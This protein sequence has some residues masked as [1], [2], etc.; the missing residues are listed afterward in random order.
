[1]NIILGAVLILGALPVGGQAWVNGT[2]MADF[3]TSFIDRV[4]AFEYY[5]AMTGDGRLKID[6]N[7]MS[8]SGNVPLAGLRRV[9]SGAGLAFLENFSVNRIDR[10]HTTNFGAP[11]SPGISFDNR[12]SFNGTWVIDA[13]MHKSLGRNVKSHQIYSGDFEIKNTIVFGG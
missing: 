7:K 1:M 9:R 3:S 11:S 12:A 2:G 8:Y 13:S 10:S 5:S 4:K 6:D